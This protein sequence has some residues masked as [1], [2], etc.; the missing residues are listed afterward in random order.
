MGGK[1]RVAGNDK[2]GAASPGPRPLRASRKEA[3]RVGKPKND[4]FEASQ[5]AKQDDMRDKYQSARVACSK[6]PKTTA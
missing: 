1:P 2:I 4:A 6:V 3:R 5:Y